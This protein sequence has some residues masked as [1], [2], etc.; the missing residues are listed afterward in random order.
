MT[1]TITLTGKELQLQAKTCNNVYSSVP[2]SSEFVK[3][4]RMCTSHV[5][6]MN[7]GKHITKHNIV[8]QRRLLM[9]SKKVTNNEQAQLQAV[10]R[11]VY[12]DSTA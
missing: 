9:K 12:K 10:Q 5:V 6:I 1:V 4:Q 11:V 3:Q 7:C 8:T 2:N